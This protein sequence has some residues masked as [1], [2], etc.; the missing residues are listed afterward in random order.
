MGNQLWN[1]SKHFYLFLILM[2]KK[3]FFK[4]KVKSLYNFYKHIF[5]SSRLQ[6]F[7]KIN[8]LKNFA[9]PRVK[10]IKLAGWRLACNFKRKKLKKFKKTSTQVCFSMKFAKFLRT[11]FFYR[12]PPVTA[13]VFF[14]KSKH[15]FETLL[16]RTN[17]FFLSTHCLMYKKSNSFVYKFVVNCQALERTLT[18]C[19]LWSWKLAC[20]ITW[21]I[22]FKTPFFRYLSMCL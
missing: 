14:L 8:A 15:Y 4:C 20:L 22:L 21:T 1:K 18:G 5:R 19:T 9:I 2:L 13:S 17:I 6:M 3:L 7:F 11:I 10:F 16:W 12:I